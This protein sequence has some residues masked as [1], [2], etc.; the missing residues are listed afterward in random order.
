M[1]LPKCGHMV[2]SVREHQLFEA[3]VMPCSR[4]GLQIM[5]G[6]KIIEVKSPL[7]TKGS[8]TKR[9]LTQD[10]YDFIFAMGDDTTDEDTFRELPEFAYSVKVGQISEIA[11]YSVKSQSKVLPLL[12]LI[13][14]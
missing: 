9:L 1:A 7:H 11:R 4:Q 12:R 13:S 2:A 14:E 5:R 3:L 6:N 10:S 8:E